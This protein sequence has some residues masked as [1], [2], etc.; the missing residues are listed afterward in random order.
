M[1]RSSLIA[2]FLCLILAAA[3]ATAEIRLPTYESYVEQPPEVIGSAENAETVTSQYYTDS[4]SLAEYRALLESHGFLQ[5]GK[6]VLPGGEGYERVDVYAFTWIGSEPPATFRMTIGEDTFSV[7]ILLQE[8]ALT[9]GRTL[10]GIT[11]SAE[12]GFFEYEKPTST[13]EPTSSPT[14]LPAGMCTHCNKGRCKECGGSGWQ[15]CGICNGFRTC[16]TCGGKRRYYVASYSGG[17]GTYVDCQGC[18]GSGKCWCCNGSGTEDCGW[19]EGGVCP[20]CHGNYL[21]P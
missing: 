12:I 16:P 2:V 18:Y 6:W 8:A 13:P 1:K 11:C 19:C 7:H 9:N 15:R 5:S 17:S 14:P 20:Y 21:D 3:C 4:K 10:A